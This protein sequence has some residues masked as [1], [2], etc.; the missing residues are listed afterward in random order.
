MDKEVFFLST[1]ESSKIKSK[2]FRNYHTHLSELK[3][4]GFEE[5]YG[6]MAATEIQNQI[7]PFTYHYLLYFTLDHQFQIDLFQK[8]NNPN[9]IHSFSSW[10]QNGKTYCL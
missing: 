5:K 6:F 2:L 3:L 8:I 10:Q 1:L 7:V 9:K 4:L